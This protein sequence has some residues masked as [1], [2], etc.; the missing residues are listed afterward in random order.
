M[1]TRLIVF[2]LLLAVL[3]PAGPLQAG[4][5]TRQ[6]QDFFAAK[7]AISARFVQTVQGA[8]FA[9]PQESHGFL[10]MQ[11]PGKFRWDYETPYQQLIVADGRSLWIYDKDLEQVIVKP[12][13]QALG[14]T[15]AMLL[16]G[17]GSL[18]GRF[19]VSELP[20]PR[21][22]LYWVQLLPRQEDPSFKELRLGFNDNGL[23]AMELVDGFGQ[24]TRLEFSS[25]REDVKV[26]AGSF[27]F[28]PPAGVDV[29][30]QPAAD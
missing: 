7:G 5:A 29:V 20:E 28:A 1:K 27:D 14:D 4:E 16:S 9:Q 6:L 13:D 21:E 30:G 3:L 15:P 26:P 10:L 25:L 2:C 8:A 19:V 18:E 11:R 22:G 12:L 17:Q 24:L 23:A